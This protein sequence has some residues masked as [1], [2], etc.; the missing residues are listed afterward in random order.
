MYEAQLYKK[1]LEILAPHKVPTDT[2]GK[3]L[4]AYCERWRAY[5]NAAHILQ[6]FELAKTKVSNLSPASLKRLEL[7]ILYHD[8]WYKVGRPAGENEQRS[9][10][11]AKSDLTHRDNSPETVELCRVVEQGILATKTHTLNG[12]DAEYV[13]EVATL[14]DLDLWGIG[15]PP[16]QFQQDTEKVWREYQPIVSRE[17]FDA[18]R[19]AWARTFLDSRPN[20]YQTS[21]FFHLEDQAKRNLEQLAKQ[22]K[23]RK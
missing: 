5:H 17:E 2:A 14:I 4:L 1:I 10:D 16:E 15:Q 3:L 23:R 18:G 7:M 20:I 19:S 12:I 9:A 13:D 8:A 22:H 6:M 21:S 11:W